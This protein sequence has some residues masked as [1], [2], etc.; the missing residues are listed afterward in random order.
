[1]AHANYRNKTHLTQLAETWRKWQGL[2]DYWITFSWPPTTKKDLYKA[3]KQL[4]RFI[5]KYIANPKGR[6]KKGA[7]VEWFY[8]GDHCV[9]STRPHFHVLLRVVAGQIPQL[10]DIAD[11]W[12]LWIK[13]DSDEA[14][15]I[16]RDKGLNNTYGYM[17][18]HHNPDHWGLDAVDRRKPSVKREA[19]ENGLTSKSHLTGARR[20]RW[21]ASWV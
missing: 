15:H 4:S 18:R 13:W 17:L 9:G 20:L 2:S 5:V 12:R 21:L 14:V 1:M 6:W 7:S 10:T 16:R 3:Q 8:A 19:C 11:G